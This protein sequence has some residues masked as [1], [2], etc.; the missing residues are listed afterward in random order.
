MLIISVICWEIYNMFL[1]SLVSP[2]TA[3]YVEPISS[4]LLPVVSGTLQYP[5][6]ETW[7]NADHGC[8]VISLNCNII[9][10]APNF[11]DT[12]TQNRVRLY[13][14]FA[15]FAQI[16]DD[17]LSLRG[18]TCASCGSQ[19]TSSYQFIPSDSPGIIFTNV[20]VF[21]NTFEVL[22][23]GCTHYHRNI[24]PE[25]CELNGDVGFAEG[26]HEEGGSEEEE[27]RS[28]EDLKRRCHHESIHRLSSG[29]QY[30]IFSVN[31]DLTAYEYLHRSVV[32]QAELAAVF[33]KEASV[34][35]YRN[36]HRPELRRLITFETV[37]PES[38]SK[39]LLS[40]QVR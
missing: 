40:L 10:W 27:D 34:I 7:K 1:P 17:S 30:R 23:N 15:T 21:G 26:F 16:E 28:R 37:K 19:S 4:F 39:D 31:R 14:A 22:D 13:Q 32:N 35:L 36:P 18:N 6:L 12:Q 38:P 25:P 11:L 8:F 33:D 9:T 20:D 3:R 2:K 24:P 29:T 5:A